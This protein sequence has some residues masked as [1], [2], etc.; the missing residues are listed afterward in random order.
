MYIISILINISVTT[1]LNIEQEKTSMLSV[2]NPGISLKTSVM[3]EDMKSKMQII[4]D[5]IA[6][7]N[8]L[9]KK[10]NNSS[11]SIN[12]TKKCQPPAG[13]MPDLIQ[14]VHVPSRGLACPPNKNQQNEKT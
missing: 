13:D 2:P 9:V 12:K 3:I 8:S 5:R 14:T 7:L 10:S 1:L 4:E 11:V 6:R